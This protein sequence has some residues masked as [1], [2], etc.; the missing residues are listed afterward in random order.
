MPVLV[1]FFLFILGSAVG[2]FLN[3]L[4]DRSETGESPFEGR[5]RC[6]FCK[7]KLSWYDLIPLI[8]FV[9]LNG[10]CRYCSKKL[11][12]YYPVVELTA[13]VLFVLI[14]FMQTGIMNQES[15]I[16]DFTSLTY[17]LLIISVLIVIFF[18]DLKYGIIPFSAVAFGVLVSLAYVLLNTY[19][20]LPNLLLSGLG[21]FLAFLL[22]FLA[23]RGRGMGFG[24]VVYVFLMGIILGF[25]KII[26]GLYVAFITG[27]IVSLLLIALKKKKLKGDTI[28]FGP[29]LVAGTIISLFWGDTLIAL[30]LSYLH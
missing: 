18:T 1:A 23:T 2:S 13:G 5:S 16:M 26:P 12:A 28:P 25:P 7:H 4:V 9:A 24:D 17:H 21:A 29:F 15:G 22:L 27:A 20:L 14:L 8:S 11:S 10:K 30:I 3:V 19:Y 6:D